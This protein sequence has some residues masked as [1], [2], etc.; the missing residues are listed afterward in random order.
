MKVVRQQV[1][2]RA[3]KHDVYEALMD[4]RKHAKFTESKASIS[5]RVGGAIMAA[6]GYIEGQNLRL[7][8][9]E[10]IVQKW[11]AKDWPKGHYSTAAFRLRARKGKTV[12]FFTQ[13]NV[14]D[15]AYKDM[16]QGWK[17]FYWEKM[18]KTF[19]W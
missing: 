15:K 16:K 18:K 8:A 3:K 5:R 19:G 11:R 2:L 9:D 14:P 1:T 10:L 17:Y 4:S 7:K 6:G 12:L 13:R